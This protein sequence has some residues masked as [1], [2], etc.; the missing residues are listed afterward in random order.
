VDLVE[1]V[2]RVDLVE[3]VDRDKNDVMERG[4]WGMNSLRIPS[5]RSG[6]SSSVAVTLRG[7]YSVRV[8]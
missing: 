5:T 3:R 2:D 6:R 8:E 7:I 4:D 1:R